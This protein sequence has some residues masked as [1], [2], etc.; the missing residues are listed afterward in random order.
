MYFPIDL[1]GF[2]VLPVLD[3][4]FNT[5]KLY[6][7]SLYGKIFY[8][9][10]NGGS[11]IEQITQITTPIYSISF[12]NNNKGIAVS[13]DKVL[14]TSNGGFTGIEP[15][16]IPLEGI[17]PNPTTDI[18]NIPIEIQSTINILDINGK[19]VLSKIISPGELLSL[20]HLVNGVYCI[21]VKNEK[22]ISTGRIIVNHE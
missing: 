10:N 17:Y 19:T 3:V 22:G 13:D 21:K 16:L 12:L 20:S 4:D 18:I 2:G 5:S 8:S 14:Y 15:N 11:W 6:A 7:S 9:T 1:D